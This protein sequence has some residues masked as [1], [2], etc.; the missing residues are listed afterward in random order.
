MAQWVAPLT[1]YHSVVSLSFLDIGS[2]CFLEQETLPTLLCTG[3]FQ[4]QIQA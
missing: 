4:E 1:R 2:R 3:L